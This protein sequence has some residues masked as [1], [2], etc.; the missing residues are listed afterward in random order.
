MSPACS[1]RE[2]LPR[3]A[4]RGSPQVRQEQA[5]GI[6]IAALGVLAAHFG[7]GEASAR[8][9]GCLCGLGRRLSDQ[10]AEISSD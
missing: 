10:K 4:N 7:Y 1:D 2:R 6:L 5:Q 3:C 9:R 8:P